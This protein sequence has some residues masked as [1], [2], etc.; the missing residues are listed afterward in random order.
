FGSF[1][2]S[3][4]TNNDNYISP[5]LY[6]NYNSLVGFSIKGVTK[7]KD[8]LSY[9][10]NYNY[11]RASKWTSLNYSDYGKSKVDLHSLTPLVR[12]HNKFTDKG[13]TNKFQFFIECGPT[14]GISKLSL[15]KA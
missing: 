13:F 8:Y 3:E 7:R 1:V 9:G 2:G 5:S 4:I 14:I 15:S 12:F 6:S 10:L 11:L